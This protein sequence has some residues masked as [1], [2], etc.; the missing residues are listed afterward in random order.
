MPSRWLVR[1]SG[2]KPE[3]VRL[4]ALHAVFSR[5]FDSADGDHA[6]RVKPYSLS[7]PRSLGAHLIVEVGAL[8]SDLDDKL[9]T[10]T[11]QGRPVRL[12]RQHGA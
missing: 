7:P 11:V 3:Q 6:A 12:D 4:E 9:R 2:V 1:V 10:E 5:W 8:T